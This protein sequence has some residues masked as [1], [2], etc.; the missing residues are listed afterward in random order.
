MGRETAQHA[1]LLSDEVWAATQERAVLEGT[2]ASDI[3]ERVL[4]HYLALEEKPPRYDLPA[5]VA[6]RQR[7]IHVRTT[8]WAVAKAQKVREG[9]PVSVILEQLLRA[10]LG[11]PF[12]SDTDGTE[13]SL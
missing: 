13:L 3:C 7:S 11:F 4:S 12:A 6:T 2:T 9:R 10:Y 8:T 1:V 5:N